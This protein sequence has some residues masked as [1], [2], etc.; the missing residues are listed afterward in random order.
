MKIEQLST[1][2]DF[3]FAARLD[4]DDMVGLLASLLM[5]AGAFFGDARVIEK[6]CGTEETSDRRALLWR[7]IFLTC[8]RVEPVAFR[9]ASEQVARDIADAMERA[10]T[11]IPNPPFAPESAQG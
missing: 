6:L 4:H 8:A 5:G 2:E 1:P 10:A 9:G 3:A 7:D 11:Q